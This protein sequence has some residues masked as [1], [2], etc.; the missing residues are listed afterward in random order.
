MTVN[1]GGGHPLRGAAAA[2]PQ[3]FFLPPARTRVFGFKGIQLDDD[4]FDR[5]RIQVLLSLQGRCQIR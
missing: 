4:F 5:I 3:L 2:I 1:Q